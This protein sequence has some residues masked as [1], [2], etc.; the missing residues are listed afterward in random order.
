MALEQ[1]TKEING[2]KYLVTTM[3]GLR[4]LKTQTKIIK[5]LGP[6]LFEMIASGAVGKDGLDPKKISKLLSAIVPLLSSFDDE[7]VN[8]LVLS[9]FDKGIF[10]E[11]KEGNPT[12]LDFE[13]H[14]TGRIKDV[15]SVAA[16]ILEVNFS[17]G[18]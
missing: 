3:D 18:E 1:K 13:V 11:D 12:K 4:A 6:S 5:I 7:A 10:T 8:D 14:F 16:F 2:V 15:W 9:L 17:M